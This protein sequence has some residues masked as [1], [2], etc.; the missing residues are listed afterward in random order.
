MALFGSSR[1][2]M[3]GQSAP[4]AAVRL[5]IRCECPLAAPPPQC[6][7]LLATI[8]PQGRCR[9]DQKSEDHRAIIVGQLDQICLRNQSAKL[10]QLA[11]ALAALHLPRA[12]V[13][14]RPFRQQPVARRRRPLCRPSQRDQRRALTFAPGAERI[15]PR[16]CDSPPLPDL[17]LRPLATAPRPA[18]RPAARRL[19]SRSPARQ[20][21][22][23][24]FLELPGL[25]VE[26]FE[27]GIEVAGFAHRVR[28]PCLERTRQLS[29]ASISRNDLKSPDIRASRER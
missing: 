1:Q 16:A 10:D 23:L 2:T 18:P 12:R 29:S 13:M 5:R 9:F 27:F 26:R 24:A 17:C 20:A 11:R 28:P 4:L 6:E 21:V 3:S 22:N 8:A 15:P 19:R 14:P 7:H 25:V